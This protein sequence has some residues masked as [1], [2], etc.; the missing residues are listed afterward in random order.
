MASQC[1]SWHLPLA[2]CISKLMEHIT[3]WFPSP[4]YT[5]CN[6]QAYY[7][8]NYII[9]THYVYALDDDTVS[10]SLLV[11]SSVSH[12]PLL[13]VQ[14]CTQTT[15][16]HYTYLSDSDAEDLSHNI[17][18]TFSNLLCF[19]CVLIQLILQLTFAYLHCKYWSFRHRYHQTVRLHYN[20][21]CN[22]TAK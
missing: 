9:C 12:S 13:K 16:T 15:A 22:V 21:K 14:C 7:I 11:L 2:N 3:H 18:V 10:P 8:I 1:V 19:I 17:L 20:I 5:Y 6:N 4:I